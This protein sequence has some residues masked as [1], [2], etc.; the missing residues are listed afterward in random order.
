MSRSTAGKIKINTFADLCGVSG[1]SVVRIAINEL[2]DFKDHPFHVCDDEEMEK[3]AK[4]IEESDI[5]VPL[6]VRAR[7]SGG[8]EI[9]SGHRRKHAA[10]KA[11]KKDV[12]AVIKNIS[13]DEAVIAMVDSNI[14]R[15]EILPSERAFSYKMKLKAIKNQGRR[16]DLTSVQIEQKLDAMIA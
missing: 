2:W 4:S 5:L 3:L 10:L 12:P 14:Q 7:E 15:E 8:Y 9:I 11:G 13:D 1:E 16:S 6:T